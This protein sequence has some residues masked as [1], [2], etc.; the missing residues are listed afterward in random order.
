MSVVRGING[1]RTP[2]SSKNESKIAG[3]IIEEI[4]EEEDEDY[5]SPTQS[6]KE[7][8]D[9]R[10][11][12]SAYVP[13]STERRSFIDFDLRSAT[14]PPNKSRSHKSLERKV[15]RSVEPKDNESKFQKLMDK[16]GR[17]EYDSFR[18]KFR[19]LLA[20]KQSPAEP[21][22]SLFKPKRVSNMRERSDRLNKTVE[23]GE[24][25]LGTS[26]LKNH[27]LN[28]KLKPKL[29]T[30]SGR[31]LSRRTPIKSQDFDLKFSRGLLTFKSPTR[32]LKENE[33]KRPL[34]IA[35]EESFSK[36][37]LVRAAPFTD[38]S[39]QL[40][41]SEIPKVEDSLIEDAVVSNLVLPR[42]TLASN[43]G[44]E[45]PSHGSKTKTPT[46]ERVDLPFGS[47]RPV[48]HP[49]HKLEFRSNP[50]NKKVNDKF[51]VI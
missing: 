44:P 15:W 2:V 25:K 37:P 40:Q 19:D 13:K 5:G 36:R 18:G 46:H 14:E 17:S 20:R 1:T 24:R 21:A 6:V 16:A 42:R 3:Q 30:P 39:S 27:S 11:R 34:P 51:E 47:L 35:D 23:G 8:V 43:S 48:F 28:P 4:Q 38:S 7:P 50:K 10:A 45:R 31:G 12:I 32:T 33:L 22:E 41:V 29:A 26:T 9:T 49:S